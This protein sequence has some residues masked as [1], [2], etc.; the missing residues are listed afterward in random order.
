[1]TPRLGS[2]LELS[3]V[4]FRVPAGTSGSG[5]VLLRDAISWLSL[6]MS[7]VGEAVRTGAEL[8]VSVWLE[9]SGGTRGCCSVGRL[10]D[11]LE[12]VAEETAEEILFAT[13]S[14]VDLIASKIFS[15]SPFGF[16]GNIGRDT[17]MLDDGRAAAEADGGCAD[18]GGAPPPG[19][20]GPG[21]VAVIGETVLTPGAVTP[22][23]GVRSVSKEKSGWSIPPPRNHPMTSPTPAPTDPHRIFDPLGTA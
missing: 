13:T 12:V 8:K 6:L 2:G 17:V 11:C 3:C 10:V 7:G 20:M 14:A 21:D 4:V 19:I 23:T 18:A 1:M 9:P 5:G 22:G 16:V 15:G